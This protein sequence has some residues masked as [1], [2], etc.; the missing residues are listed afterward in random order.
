MSSK[1]HRGKVVF[2]WLLAALCV[3]GHLTQTAKADPC[4]MVPP[5]YP[6]EQVPLARVGEQKTYVFYQAGIETFVIRPGFEGKVEEFGMLIPFPTPPAIRKVPDNIFEHLAAAVDPP[7]IV[8]DLRP[9]VFDEVMAGAFPTDSAPMPDL[10]IQHAEVRVLREEAVGMYEVAV[11]AAGSAAALQRWMDDHGYIYPDGMDGACNDYI[12]DKWCF[13]AVKTRVG[14]KR[15]VDPQPGQRNVEAK[16]PPGASFDGFVQ[17]MGFRFRSDEL[18]VPMRL[19]AFNAGEL[20]NVVYLLT[21]KPSRI[22]SI[23]ADKVVRQIPGN[24]LY[25]NVTSP[26]PLR[27][28][29]GTESDLHNLP[30]WRKQSLPKERD[31]VPHNGL[32][33]ELFAADLLAVKHDRLSHPHEEAAKVLLRIDERLGLRGKEIDQLRHEAFAQQREAVVDEALS[34]LLTITLTVIDG[35]FPRQ[36]LAEENLTFVSYDM[37]AAENTAQVYNA[38]MMG[39][40]GSADG[41]V[42]VAEPPPARTVAG[43]VNPPAD[44]L[45]AVDL[46]A[47]PRGISITWFWIVIGAAILVVGIILGLMMAGRR[48]QSK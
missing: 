19:S 35:D 47:A 2:G 12:N 30:D 23:T 39:P 7:E 20:H 40:A 38:R 22:E 11:L 48:G 42:L 33:R 32:A 43:P 46:T 4:G 34:G 24:V 15:G 10:V 36:T 25:R 41:V 3:H 45:A 37:P 8:V 14:Q 1:I 6:G 44:P 16:L 5:V 13:V 9:Q 29:G 18:V 27:I 28:I 17:A 26:L 21:D 31:P